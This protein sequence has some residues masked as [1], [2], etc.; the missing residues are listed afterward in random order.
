MC[1]CVPPYP[2]P[3]GEDLMASENDTTTPLLNGH[4]QGTFKSQKTLTVGGK[5]IAKKKKKKQKNAV[6]KD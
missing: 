2:K 6:S 1:C 5:E 4:R 3:L